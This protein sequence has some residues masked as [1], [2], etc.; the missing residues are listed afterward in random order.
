MIWLI[1][2]ALPGLIPG[3]AQWVKD[4]ALLQLWHR[5]QKQLRF[6]PWPRGVQ[7]I[8]GGRKESWVRF[9]DWVFCGYHSDLVV[10][11]E[12]KLWRGLVLFHFMLVSG[13]KSAG[14]LVQEENRSV[15]IKAACNTTEVSLSM[16]AHFQTLGTVCFLSQ[17][18]PTPNL[19][20]KMRTFI[21]EIQISPG[22]DF[23]KSRRVCIEWNL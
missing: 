13:C 2:L 6:H 16:S 19:W 11:N 8:M 12:V 18:P 20:A 4:P 3:P 10:C 22:R 21:Q 1:S 15:S 23:A 14:L 17:T 7:P 9:C 5:S